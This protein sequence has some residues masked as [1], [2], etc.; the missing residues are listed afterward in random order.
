MTIT[1]MKT[2][3]TPIVPRFP[4]PIGIF[5]AL[6]L[7][8]LTLTCMAADWPQWRGPQRNG[9]SSETG[10]L[11]QW[12]AEGPRLLWQVKDAGKGYAAPAVAGNR[13]YLLSNEGL[14]DEFVQAHD[15]ADGRR[16]WRTR[17]GKV[18]NPN[19]QPRF[20]AARSTPTV[21]GEVLFALG[22]D[23]DLACVE[24][25]TGKI[26]WQKSLREDFGGKP[27]TWAYA[28]SPL[29]DGDL[30]LCTPGGGDATLVALDKRNGNVLWKC[31]ISGANEA[32]YASAIIV[33]TGGL[34][35]Y[36]QMISGGLVGVDAKSGRLLWRYD[37]TVS[38]YK[39][40][41]PSPVARGAW[42]FSAGA[43]TGAGTVKLTM[44]NGNVQAEEVY[45]GPK[46][47]TAIGGSVLVG[48]YL[49]GTSAQGL[50]CLD[51]TTGQVKWENP[52]LGAASLLH[53]DG[54]LY[55]HGENG[56]VAL[57]ETTPDG[58]REKGRFNP[59]NRPTRS[60]PMEKSWA[61]PVVA[62]G[63]LYLRDHDILW[64]YDVKSLTAS[65]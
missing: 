20:P 33:E 51:F 64:C 24:T 12:P 22:S 32:A 10:L 4:N 18:G 9:V 45:F 54:H 52:A 43:G 25:V 31:A 61:Y 13:L 5:A 30:L 57:V 29:V 26:R 58:Y 2:K 1:T 65:N 36:V 40:N 28:E 56:T 14:E 63:R 47:P 17:L 19:Q 16:L 27:G 23:G 41:I 55:L 11:K 44:A 38:K 59:P 37:K 48:D 62:N 35:Q 46:L 39:A 34:K 3:S 49:Y 42:V 53:A 50:M 21:D 8:I 6:T 60:Q 15:V 7:S